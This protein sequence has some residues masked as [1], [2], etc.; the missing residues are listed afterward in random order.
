MARERGFIMLD[1]LIDYLE[2]LKWYILLGIL[3]M[4]LIFIY[5]GDR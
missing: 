1:K 2:P 3:L 5:W 4:G